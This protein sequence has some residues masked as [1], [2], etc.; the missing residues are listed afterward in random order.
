MCIYIYVY[1]YTHVYPYALKRGLLWIG[2]Q[3]VAEWQAD[4]ENLLWNNDALKK[5]GV[6]VDGKSLGDAVSEK[7]QAVQ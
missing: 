5:A 1:I 2:R 6:D 4:S 7:L 3:R